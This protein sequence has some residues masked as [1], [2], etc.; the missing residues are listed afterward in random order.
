MNQKIRKDIRSVLSKARKSLKPAEIIENLSE[1]KYD[2]DD[3]KI[4]QR[5]WRVLTREDQKPDGLFIR[6]NGKYDL[7]KRVDLKER[8]I[9]ELESNGFGFSHGQIIRPKLENKEDIRRL[10]APARSDK[11]EKNKDFLEKKEEK[12]LTFFANG[13]EID[14]ENFWPKLE[15]VETNTLQSDIFKYAT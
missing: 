13:N 5:V 8:V 14:I 10:H 3:S 1:Y 12:L 9:K 15:V 6:S 11:Y 4:K 7:P 2:P